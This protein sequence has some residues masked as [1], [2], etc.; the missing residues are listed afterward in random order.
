MHNALFQHMFASSPVLDADEAQFANPRPFYDQ[1]WSK[2]DCG[3]AGLSNP[4]DLSPLE[5]LSSGLPSL[6]PPARSGALDMH[7]TQGIL[8]M[9]NTRETK[10]STVQHVRSL[11]RQH[12]SIRLKTE[13]MADLPTSVPEE[14]LPER[15]ETPLCTKIARKRPASSKKPR[16]KPA[17]QI[18]DTHPADTTW[19]SEDACVQSCTIQEAR[20][21]TND[22]PQSVQ[23]GQVVHADP[24]PSPPARPTKNVRRIHAQV[25][26]ADTLWYLSQG[27]IPTIPPPRPRK[28]SMRLGPT[29]PSTSAPL[30]APAIHL[31]YRQKDL[32]ELD[33]DSDSD[34]MSSS[35]EE[36]LSS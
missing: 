7:M 12:G 11:G 16:R 9:P 13:S 22:I 33:H 1:P 35:I 26:P 21:N 23:L 19:P 28:S 18:G 14:F 8:R 15:S 4:S 31:P 6:W 27:M 32:P 5:Q 20:V 29:P 34:S 10:V 36:P 17:P 25:N 3:L 30:P 24:A 2:S